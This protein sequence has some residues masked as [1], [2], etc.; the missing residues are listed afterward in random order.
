MN[1]KVFA[2]EEFIGLSVKVTKSNDPNWIGKTGII[3]NETKN[4]FHIKVNKKDKKIEKKNSQFEFN[5]NGNKII[6]DGSKINYR[7]EDRIKKTR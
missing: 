2:K 6:I 7:P 1:E 3:I 4:M 5:Y